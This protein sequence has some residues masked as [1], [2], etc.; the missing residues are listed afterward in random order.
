MTRAMNALLRGVACA[1]PLSLAAACG[2]ASTEQTTETGA[3]GQAQAAAPS[4]GRLPTDVAPIGYS[5]EMQIVP[6][7]PTFAGRAQIGVRLRQPR[8]T[9]WLHGKNLT[10]GEVQVVPEGG[11]PV[12]GRFEV[13]DE[14]GTARIVLPQPV[15][16]GNATI[17]IAWTAPFRDDLEGLFGVEA[18]ARRYAFTQMEPLGAR[19]AFPCFDEPAFKTPFDVSL[20]VRDVHRAIAN[21]REIGETPAGGGMKT[22]RYA[23]TQP[24]PTYLVAWAVGPLDVVDAPAIAPNAVRPTPLPFRGVAVAGR[25]PELAHALESTPAIL[26]LLEEYFGSP[27]PYDK[28]DIIAIPGFNGA[29]ENVGAVTFA[30]T[31]LLVDPETAPARQKRWFGYTMTHELAHMWFGNLVTMEWWDDLWLNEAM[32]SWM[33]T[34]MTG[35]WRPDWHADRDQVEWVLEAMDADSLE[36]ARFIRQ[37][38][39]S[40]H[41]IHNA[42]DWIT[43]TKGM[44][45]LA[46]F[47]QWLGEETF[48]EGIRSYLAAR[49]FGSATAADL[50][51]ALSQAAGRDVTPALQSFLLQSGIPM[52][53]AHVDCPDGG[54]ASVVLA[55]SRYVPAGSSAGTDRTWNV[56]V[57]VAHGT[58]GVRGQTCVLLTEESGGAPIEG[59]ACP[60]WVMPNAGASGYYRWTLS[61]A[62]LGALRTEGLEQ[63]TV[64]ERM[65]VADSLQAAFEAGRSPGADVL[66][67]LEP[68]ARDE[69]RHVATMPMSLVGFVGEYVLEEDARPRF[70]RW[71]RGLYAQRLARLGWQPRA[72]ESQEDGMLRA[73][74]VGFLALVAEDAGARRQAAQRA[75]RYL[76]VGR[77]GAI[78]EDA[79]APDMLSTVL[80]VAA[81]DGDAELFDA[82]LAHLTSTEN[83]IL[84][85]QLLAALGSFREPALAARARELTVDPRIRSD[86]RFRAL[87]AQMDDP[88]TREDA[89]RFLTERYE[90][91]AELA[92][93]SI[94]TTNLPGLAEP[95]CTV[96]RAE[97]V[98]RF[99]ARRIERLQGGPR[100]L[101]GAVESIRLCAARVAAQ[102]ESTAEFFAARR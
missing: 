52:I 95:F 54:T 46:M 6:D 90:A 91:I 7:Q 99:F 38:I 20:T 59:D 4:G 65:S 28:L 25:G 13:V 80:V 57:C 39:T 45:V 18:G 8:D 63:L 64:P 77:D 48:R 89:W 40:T 47:E 68:L 14:D 62:L 101:A 36:S 17:R 42:F 66:A 100:N 51:G 67:A 2:A 43:Y 50:A 84:R 71:A 83:G 61:A 31:I 27:Y 92:G 19:T 86:E 93:A 85:R 79:V 32:A 1:I 73:E 15:G 26:A 55:Q 9:I 23:T 102:R 24:I 16:P 96:E 94:W 10:V 70:L 56:P 74:V 29:M 53:E 22:I 30:D 37:P 21:T 72:N 78:H 3:A 49:P 97:E 88:R 41:D 76:G 81:Q 12:V 5:L 33:E 34:K 60:D 44:G 35:R 82:M 98:E 69:A 87:R 58:G 75:R 11:A